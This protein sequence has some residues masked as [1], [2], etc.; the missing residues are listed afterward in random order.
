MGPLEDTVSGGELVYVPCPPSQAVPC[1]PFED[2]SQ[3]YQ[4][5]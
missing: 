3:A 4:P 2:H 5:N 1:L